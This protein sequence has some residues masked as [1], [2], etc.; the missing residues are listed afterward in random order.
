MND[1]MTRLLMWDGYPL[2]SH[3]G[4]YFRQFWDVSA[5][6]SHESDSSD[7]TAIDGW[8]RRPLGQNAP[9]G[10]PAGGSL[11]LLIRSELLR[12]YPKTAIYCGKAKLDPTGKKI[13]DEDHEYYSVFSGTLGTDITFIGYDLSATDV[14]GAP[15]DYF[16]VFEEHPTE[17]RFGLEP[18]EPSGGV[19][20]WADLAWTNLVADPSPTLKSFSPGNDQPKM[21]STATG[22]R[23]LQLFTTTDAARQLPRFLSPLVPLNRVRIARTSSDSSVNWGASSAQTA[24]ALLRQPYRI[25]VDAQLMF[26][27][28]TS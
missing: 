13:L 8:G 4:T 1:E 26:K 5:A 9:P 28:P 22:R 25:V 11:V 15:E 18:A 27:E 7:I 14:M 3:R 12:R 6:V 17:Q 20:R 10:K 24:S 23:T 21:S 19:T 16:V 2:P